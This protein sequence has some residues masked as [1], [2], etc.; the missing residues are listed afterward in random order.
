MKKIAMILA[1]MLVAAFAFAQS[2][3]TAGTDW[4]GTRI[5]NG[6]KISD[7][8]EGAIAISDATGLCW[9]A[10]SG[11][12]QIGTGS[13]GTARTVQINGRQ[14]LDANGNVPIAAITN[15]LTSGTFVPTYSNTTVHG[16][17]IVDGAGIIT[18]SGAITGSI[19]KATA[20]G[21]I[22]S[23]STFNGIL[24]MGGSAI[25]TNANL[26]G[27]TVRGALYVGTTA[28]SGQTFI[29]TNWPGGTAASNVIYVGNG[30]ITNQVPWVTG[31]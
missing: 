9:V 13:N 5:G 23:N 3:T 24:G 7:A 21:S 14:I 6:A 1:V 17:F 25:V 27:A 29:Y 8:V 20:G 16:W 30:I 18:A 15:A 4:T 12:I 28:Q 10:A 2:N 11:A 31:M 22:F 19:F 26:D